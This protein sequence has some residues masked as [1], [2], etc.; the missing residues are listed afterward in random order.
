MPPDGRSSLFVVFQAFYGSSKVLYV[1]AH[2]ICF[3]RGVFLFLFF[4]RFLVVLVNNYF[5]S[6]T[7]W[8]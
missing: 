7:K 6:K 8:V 2:N 3:S 5:D 4:V 1:T